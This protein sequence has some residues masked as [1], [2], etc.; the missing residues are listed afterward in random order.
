MKYSGYFPLRGRAGNAAARRHAEVRWTGIFRL[1][2]A[3]D[4]MKL[5]TAMLL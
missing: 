3:P 2:G 1:N 4:G 5:G